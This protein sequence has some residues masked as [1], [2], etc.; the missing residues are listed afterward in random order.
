M[1]GGGA[2]MGNGASNEAN[3]RAAICGAIGLFAIWVAVWLAAGAAL[4]KANPQE[5]PLSKL[6]NS[7]P[8]PY[9]IAD[10][11]GAPGYR[12]TDRELA[13]WA[14]QAWQRSVGASLTFEPA[15]ESKALVRIYWAAPEDEE[16]GEMKPLMVGGRR[17]SAVFIRPDVNE[18]GPET[19][20]PANKDPL[21]RETIVYLTCLHELGHALGLDHT[22]D[23]SDIMFYF[24]Y[25]GDIPEYFA[26]YRR[27]LHTR[28]DIAKVSGL[29]E[30]DVS[31]IRALYVKG[32]LAQNRMSPPANQSAGAAGGATRASMTARISAGIPSKPATMKKSA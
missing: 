23:Y 9:F 26:R 27:Q 3:R 25:G 13:L 17:G 29:S 5:S 28:S 22:K 8:I 24:G 10:G 32:Q 7:K 11:K 18:L 19:A 30:S 15:V 20:E 16:F 6:D 4:V 12:A 14:L 31:R 2:A 21:L 1:I